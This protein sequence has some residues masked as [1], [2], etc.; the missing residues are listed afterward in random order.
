M[1]RINVYLLPLTFFKDE[2][3]ECDEFGV[4]EVAG[5]EIILLKLSSFYWF[6]S[7][8]ENLKNL[9]EMLIGLTIIR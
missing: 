5:M 1:F 8:G 4:G 9:F 2:V 6:K 3:D 7:C